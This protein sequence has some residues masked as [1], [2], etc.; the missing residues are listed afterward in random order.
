MNC[1]YKT[2]NSL[3]HSEKQ[4]IKNEIDQIVGKFITEQLNDEIDKFSE[5]LMKNC[6][7]FCCIAVRDNLGVSAKKVD[8]MI[9]WMFEQINREN[10][11]AEDFWLEVDRDLK[12]C[13][14][15]EIYYKYFEDNRF[16]S[17]ERY[18]KSL[19]VTEGEL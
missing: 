6:I 11:E 3:S 7:K 10:L 18:M 14:G 12:K 8:G 2:I 19:K 1:K 17:F 4:K 5:K 16:I 13:I 9:A 15:K